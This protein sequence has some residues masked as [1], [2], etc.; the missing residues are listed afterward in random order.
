MAIWICCGGCPPGGNWQMVVDDLAAVLEMNGVE[1]R[2]G[3][4]ASAGALAAESPDAV[5]CATGSTWD[6]TGFSAAR[7]DRETMPGADQDHVLDVATAARAALDDPGSLGARVLILDDTGTYLPLGLAE[8]LGEGGVEVEVLSRFPVIGELVAGT[9]DLPW[10]LPRLAKL[11]VRLSPNH[12]IES[13]DGSRVDVYET[14]TRRSRPVE[15]VGTVV[16]SMMRSPQDALFRELQTAGTTPTHCI[17]DAV[18]PRSIA[19]AIYEGEKL[20]RAL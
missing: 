17:G 16:L 14:L 7:P 6:R 9:Q 5:V 4:T 3:E 8:L 15:G 12:F 13:I 1:V 2:L 20:G 19:E 18:A 11:D 10:L